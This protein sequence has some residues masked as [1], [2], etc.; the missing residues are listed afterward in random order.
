MAR[1][2]G[3]GRHEGS[4]LGRV[5]GRV[6]ATLL[7]DTAE[8]GETDDDVATH[9]GFLRLPNNANFQDWAPAGKDPDS[10]S[11]PATDRGSK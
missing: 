9:S 10:P 4:L 2:A 7:A 6:A 3:V 1:G 8:G 11:Q 5:L